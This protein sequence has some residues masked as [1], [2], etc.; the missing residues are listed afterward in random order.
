M[1]YKFPTAKNFSGNLG[2]SK[3]L[4]KEASQL[5]QSSVKS[6]A[7]INLAYNNKIVNVN[8]GAD[9]KFSDKTDFGFTAGLDRLFI[10]VIPG[11]ANAIAVNPSFYTYAGTQN[12]TQ[13]YYEKKKKTNVLGLPIGN[14]NGNGNDDKLITEEVKRFAVLDQL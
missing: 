12:F 7:E 9:A 5:V 13:Y 4:Y 1:G 10:Y 11:T 6:L 3:F 2:F 14:G 8:A